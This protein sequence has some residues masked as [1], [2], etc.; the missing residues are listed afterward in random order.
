MFYNRVTSDVIRFGD[1]LTGFPLSSSKVDNPIRGLSDEYDIST[2]IPKYSI[3]IDPSCSIGERKISLSPLKRIPKKLYD[4]PILRENIKILNEF[5]RPELGVHPQKWNDMSKEDKLF[6]LNGE[7]GL[8]NLN[9][10]IYDNHDLLEEYDIT[11]N[12]IY[13]ETVDKDGF[14]YY[15]IRKDEVNYTTSMYFLDFKEIYH[16]KCDKIIDQNN[17]KIERQILGSKI[18]ELSSDTRKILGEKYNSYISRTI[19]EDE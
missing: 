1:I 16:V 17:R 11:S 5:M 19:N 6:L 3:V 2:V 18:L 14:L 9:I 7:V 13:E 8:T 4:H 12:I 15:S 10:F